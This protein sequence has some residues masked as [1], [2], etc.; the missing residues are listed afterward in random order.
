[1]DKRR[2]CPNCRAFITTDDKVCPYCQF[3]V[4][5][6]AVERREGADAFGGLIP[7]AR[8]TTTVIL[9]IN[10]G[11]YIAMMIHMQ[12][13]GHGMSFDFDG[14]TEV[15][16]GAKFGPLMVQYGEWWRLVTAGFLHGGIVHILMNS[17]VLFDL[18]TQTEESYGTARYLTIYFVSSVLGFFVSFFWSPM[19][20]SAGASAG[21]CG[22]I[23]AMV[24]LGVR[25]KSFWGAQMRSFYGRYVLYVLGLAVVSTIFQL[26]VDNAAHMG[27]LA[28]GFV[29]GYVAGTPGR[30]HLRESLWQI[31]A[32]IALLLTA[33]SFFKMFIELLKTKA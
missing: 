3:T 4:G 26:P 14:R 27:G 7:Q 20:V 9:L 29:V 25:D 1:M 28:S 22:L 33:Y 15:D 12:S 30:S 11:L 6:K 18:G 19:T 31:T 13:G 5:A 17:W 2:M 10:T 24:A 8:F 21:I 23:G 32:G 16:F